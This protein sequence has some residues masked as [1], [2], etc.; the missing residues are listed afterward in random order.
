MTAGL[1]PSN[2]NPCTTATKVLKGQCYF[3][4][5]VIDCDRAHGY[6]AGWRNNTWLAANYNGS[7]SSTLQRRQETIKGYCSCR[8]VS[9]LCFHMLIPLSLSL[10]FA[11]RLITAMKTALNPCA[12]LRALTLVTHGNL[13][14]RLSPP[15]T[16]C[17][18]RFA[19]PTATCL[20][21][22]YWASRR[23]IC[24]ICTEIY[25]THFCQFVYTCYFMILK[26]LYDMCS[27]AD[28]GRKCAL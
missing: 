11:Q 13:P 2:I 23:F 16:A 24:R 21:T 7:S 1:Q 6:R 27:A 8:E 9:R 12:A 26:K 25:F 10:S 3:S 4:T 18:H 19:W 5:T 14:D 20:P 22:A 28:G 15:T 17:L